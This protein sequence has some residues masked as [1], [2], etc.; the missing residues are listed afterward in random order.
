MY[1]QWTLPRVYTKSKKRNRS[2]SNASRVTAQ[3]YKSI[4]FDGKRSA[5]HPEYLLQPRRNRRRRG[6]EYTFCEYSEK[7][8]KITRSDVIPVAGT[9]D[10]S[11]GE[12]SN[13]W[14][15]RYPCVV[16]RKDRG[17]VERDPLRWKIDH[18]ARRSSSSG[19]FCSDRFDLFLKI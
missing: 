4:R 12:T 16:E 10:S 18:R 3:N 19:S 11:R 6:E 5:L 9:R 13:E 15:L 8:K 14:Q 1:N 17:P 7:K 2:S